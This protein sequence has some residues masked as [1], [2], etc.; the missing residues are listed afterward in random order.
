MSLREENPPRVFRRRAEPRV[1]NTPRDTP[2]VPL[3]GLPAQGAG[4][5]GGRSLGGTPGVSDGL[6]RA[7]LRLDVYPLE[8]VR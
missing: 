3:A 7:S 4:F 5:G 2:R 6:E 1:C 8:N